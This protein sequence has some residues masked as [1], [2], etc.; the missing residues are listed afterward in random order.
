MDY[1]SVC[2]CL[3]MVHYSFIQL[4]SLWICSDLFLA[5]VAYFCLAFV[6]REK[7]RMQNSFIALNSLEARI[8]MRLAYRY[9]NVT[10]THL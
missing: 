1:C 3:P 6:K 9:I 7:P 2:V 8:R 5:S 10:V 4:A